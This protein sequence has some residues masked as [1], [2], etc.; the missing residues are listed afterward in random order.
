[1]MSEGMTMSTIPKSRFA[2][3][4]EAVKALDPPVTHQYEFQPLIDVMATNMRIQARLLERVARALEQIV[5]HQEVKKIEKN[6]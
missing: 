5:A 2:L 3:I 6:Y 4:S 1:M